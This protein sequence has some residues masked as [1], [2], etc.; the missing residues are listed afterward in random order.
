M[1]TY[2]CGKIYEVMKTVFFVRVVASVGVFLGDHS[3]ALG[4][5]NRNMV[6]GSCVPL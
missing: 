3:F 6:M 1:W 4:E 5:K 2:V